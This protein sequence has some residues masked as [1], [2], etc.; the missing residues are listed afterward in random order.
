[1]S[2]PPIRYHGSDGERSATLRRAGDPLRP[3]VSQRHHRRLPRHRV[4]GRVVRHLPLVDARC[5]GGPGLHF[6]RRRPR[7]STCSS[8][9]SRSST[10]AGLARQRARGTS[11]TCRSAAS[12]ASATTRARSPRCSSTFAGRT[13]R[14]TSGN[15]LRRRQAGGGRLGRVLRR[16]RQRV[17]RGVV[18]PSGEATAAACSSRSS[19]AAS[20]TRPAAAVLGG[21]W[22]VARA[23]DRHRVGVR[24]DPRERDLRG[25]RAD[26]E[27]DVPDGD[28]E[29]QQPFRRGAPP[30]RL[31]RR[32]GFGAPS[33]PA[34]TRAS[35][36]C[37]SGGE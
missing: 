14:A 6:H 11:C 33:V 3:R 12:T 22:A 24:D 25:R 28:L 21:C 36:P 29:R 35:T 10:D 13:A 23:R 19:A 16:A 18:V 1:M 34:P 4:H 8:A 32:I 27:G 20:S 30:Q 17:G 15:G 7:A 31:N 2:Y 9:G 5:R 37:P 26:P